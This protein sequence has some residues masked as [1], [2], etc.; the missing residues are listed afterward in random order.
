MV[1]NV[2]ENRDFAFIKGN[3]PT[4]ANAIKAKKKSIEA[5]GLLCPII[6]VKGEQVIASKGHL[7]S[8]SGDELSDDQASNYYAVID[9]QHRLKAYLELGLPLDQ[10]VI[11]EPLNTVATTALIIAEMNICTRTWRSAD[12]MAAPAMA[13]ESTNEAFE[14]AIQLQQRGFPLAT[15]SMW[16]CGNNSLKAKDLVNCLKNGE[17]PSI[18]SDADGWCSKSKKWFFAASNQFTTKFLAKKYLITFIQNKYNGAD[19]PTDFAQKM[20]NK[21]NLLTKEQADNIMFARKTEEKTQ[22]QV[23]IEL[24]NQYLG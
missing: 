9:G 20:E 4:D 11:T 14:F 16:C 17:M 21:L 3:R 15:I 22:E 6:V 24:L 8:M 2:N 18:F 12:Y 1:T 7:I 23:T 10:I 5:Y 13:L 19:N